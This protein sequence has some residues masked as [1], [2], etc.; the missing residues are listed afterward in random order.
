MKPENFIANYPARAF[1]CFVQRFKSYEVEEIHGHLH[2]V[3][4]SLIDDRKK[5]L[6]MDK[7]GSWKRY[8]KVVFGL[9]IIIGNDLSVCAILWVHK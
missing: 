9:G 7:A 5:I 3:G 6:V 8:G 4:G 2:I 1:S